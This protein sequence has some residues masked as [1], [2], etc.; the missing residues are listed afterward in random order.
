VAH[1]DPLSPPC[2]IDVDAWWSGDVAQ[3]DIRRSGVH[4]PRW[5]KIRL[6]DASGQPMEARVNGESSSAIRI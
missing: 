4:A 3:L 5:S 2:L 1:F 6:E